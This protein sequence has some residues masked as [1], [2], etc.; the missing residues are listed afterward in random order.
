MSAWQS[1]GLPISGFKRILRWFP[2]ALVAL[3][4]LLPVVLLSGE[5]A[6]PAAQGQTS[7]PLIPCRFLDARGFSWML[8][9]Q[10][11]GEHPL[12]R[13][14]FPI[15]EQQA[16]AIPQ[17]KPL[18]LVLPH[19]DVAAPMTARVL[20]ETAAV[21]AGLPAEEHPDVIVL[22]GPNHKR[23]GASRVQTFAGDW[24]TPGGILPLARDGYDLVA[25][26]FGAAGDPALMEREH[27]L[28]YLV[29]WLHHFFP[30]TEILPVLIH[31]NLDGKGCD[32]L[33]GTL[34][35]YA[36]TR[37]VLFVAS[38]DF[39]HGL[40]PSEALM[41]DETTWRLVGAGDTAA[42][43]RLD[44]RYLD[45]P[46]TLGTLMRVMSA[47]GAQTPHLAGHAEASLFLGKPPVETTSYLVLSYHA[48]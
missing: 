22:L 42:I 27:A 46:P 33:A 10:D 16:E 14:Q 45:A 5:P 9:S 12:W 31:G 24:E 13:T 47:L 28:S 38:V 44:N 7:L 8:A 30:G 32:E 23:I 19:H 39:S 36:Q 26:T 34:R 43:Q 3:E 11:T 25:G 29:P 2:L 20:S 1:G 18:G 41:A 37:K 17:K 15:G 6:V 4:L 21:F 35:A 40:S 48:G